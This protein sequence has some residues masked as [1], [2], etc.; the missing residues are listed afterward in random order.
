MKCVHGYANFINLTVKIEINL[1][2]GNDEKSIAKTMP[3]KEH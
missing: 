1:F 2:C 3:I